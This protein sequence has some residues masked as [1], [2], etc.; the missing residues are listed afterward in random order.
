M[1]FCKFSHLSY[2]KEVVLTEGLEKTDDIYDSFGI[3][4][5]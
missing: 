2:R 3:S 1:L 5:P 4:H